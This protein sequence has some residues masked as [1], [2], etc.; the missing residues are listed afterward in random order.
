MSYIKIPLTQIDLPSIEFENSKSFCETLDDG[1]SFHVDPYKLSSLRLDVEGDLSSSGVSFYHDDPNNDISGSVNSKII[2]GEGNTIYGSF[3][4]ALIGYD[5]VISGHKNIALNSA[6]SFVS[7]DRN[8]SIAGRNNNFNGTYGSC[9]IADNTSSQTN[10]SFDNSLVVGNDKSFLLGS[11]SFLGS[12]DF[13]GTLSCSEITSQEA[14]FPSLAVETVELLNPSDFLNDTYISGSFYSAETFAQN[15]EGSLFL[16]G[17]EAAT[18]EWVDEQGYITSGISANYVKKINATDFVFNDDVEINVPVYVSGD[19]VFVGAGDIDYPLFNWRISNG[20]LSSLGDVYFGSPTGASI[21]TEGWFDSQG[22][23][24]SISINSSPVESGFDT[25]SNLTIKDAITVSEDITGDS[26]YFL[27]NSLFDSV[28]ANSGNIDTLNCNTG[29]FL[30]NLTIEELSTYNINPE[31]PS[32]SGGT[33]DMGEGHVYITGSQAVTEDFVYANCLNSIKK[34]TF[35]NSSFETINQNEST[36]I[37]DSTIT[38]LTVSGDF[39]S[40]G[41]LSIETIDLGGN[42]AVFESDGWLQV[43]DV[44]SCDSFV[45]F[46][47]SSPYEDPFKPYHFFTNGKASLVLKEYENIDLDFGFQI[48]GSLDYFDRFMDNNKFSYDGSMEKPNPLYSYSVESNPDFPALISTEDIQA[49]YEPRFNKYGFYSPLSSE[50][51]KEFIKLEASNAASTGDPF[52]SVSYIEE[53]VP[54]DINL[55]MN[56]IHDSGAS[57]YSLA[58]R[59]TDPFLFSPEA[60][61][62]ED[63]ISE[64][65]VNVRG[66]G[67]VKFNGRKAEYV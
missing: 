3:N 25:N 60:R 15:I 50:E 38:N 66:G 53:N 46:G 63:F 30:S 20:Y 55:L 27:G 51:F 64:L 36:A 24:T 8:I 48:S 6:D 1:F 26:F 58:S 49:L 40:K 9:I 61:V 62:E 2:I 35:T 17:D 57:S 32:I 43:D 13:G 41:E 31:A 56:F 10:V 12:F 34:I 52:I 7:G 16:N 23:S 18:Q 47:A 45:V 33:W 39:T 42:K 44:I 4:T 11:S 67:Q 19:F 14:F 21:A 54:Y 37:V 29:L 5:N 59:I 65:V 28:T 22:Y